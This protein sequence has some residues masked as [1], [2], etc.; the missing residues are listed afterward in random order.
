MVGFGLGI[1]GIQATGQILGHSAAQP[2]GPI[3]P[4]GWMNLRQP[5]GGMGKSNDDGA[6]ILMV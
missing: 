5:K 1:G 4:L 3:Q 6:G 2:C